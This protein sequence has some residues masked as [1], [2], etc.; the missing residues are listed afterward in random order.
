MLTQHAHTRSQQ[1]WIPP[2]L[3]HLLLIFGVSE[4]APG[5][6]EK[7]FFDKSSRKRMRAYAGPLAAML[8]QHQDIYAVVADGNK[9]IM[10]APIQI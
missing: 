8:E 9:V 5:G 2:M 1:R 3:I 10:L 4:K 6:A 7:V